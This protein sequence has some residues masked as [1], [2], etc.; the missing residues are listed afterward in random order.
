MRRILA[1]VYIAL[2]LAVSATAP[3]EPTECLIICQQ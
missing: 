3:D 1:A 2:I